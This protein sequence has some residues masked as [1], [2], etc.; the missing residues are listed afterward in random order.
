[1]LNDIPLAFSG[2][3]DIFSALNIFQYKTSFTPFE[4]GESERLT[5][6][7][8]IPL[9]AK[10]GVAREIVEIFGEQNEGGFISNMP[11]V[12]MGRE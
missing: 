7:N 11:G 12:F 1:L 10:G 8:K 6:H 5:A 2:S 4:K 3:I 9:F